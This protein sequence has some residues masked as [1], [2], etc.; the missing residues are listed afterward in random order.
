MSKICITLIAA[1]TVGILSFS[2]S[3]STN[4]NSRKDDPPYTPSPKTQQCPYTMT[5]VKELGDSWIS[6]LELIA[7]TG[8]IP[9]NQF[10][11]KIDEQASQIKK[12]QHEIHEN[13]AC[14]EQYIFLRD[15]VLQAHSMAYKSLPD[16]NKVFQR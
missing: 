5:E 16:L 14:I 1:M 15:V 10:I 7:R 11:L 12:I 13:S 4:S 2:C 3:D 6:N 9:S 8:R